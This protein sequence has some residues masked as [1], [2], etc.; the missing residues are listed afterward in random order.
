MPYLVCKKSV[1]ML[2]QDTKLQLHEVSV[3][4][5]LNRV[6]KSSHPSSPTLGS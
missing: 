1:L 3:I 4:L 2:I 5:V 6:S